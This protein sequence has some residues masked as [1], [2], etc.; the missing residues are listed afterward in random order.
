MYTKEEYEKR[1]KELE[2]VAMEITEKKTPD[3]TREMISKMN[4][5]DAHI[6]GIWIGKMLQ[7]DEFMNTISGVVVKIVKKEMP[8]VEKKEVPNEFDLN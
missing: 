4:P 1:I 5:E 3:E 7:L 2:P 6:L 8:N